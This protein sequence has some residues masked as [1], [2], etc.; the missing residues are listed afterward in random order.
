MEEVF[1]SDCDKFLES[2]ISIFNIRKSAKAEITSE[3][4]ALTANIVFLRKWNTADNFA[5]IWMMLRETI[6]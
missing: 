1:V 4:F 2:D 6:S 5:S 3:V